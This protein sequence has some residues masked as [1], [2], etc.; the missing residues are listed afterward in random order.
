MSLELHDRQLIYFSVN[1]LFY[2]C[3]IIPAVLL[4]VKFR[5]DRAAIVNIAFSTLS[6]IIKSVN[7]MFAIFETI[8]SYQGYFT[9]LDIIAAVV[10]TLSLYYF[11]FEMLFV[12]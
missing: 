2:L 12:Y 9:I 7:W 1:I 6:I 8:P 5:L 3:Y 11:T 10:V 4:V